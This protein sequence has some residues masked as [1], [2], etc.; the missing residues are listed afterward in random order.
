MPFNQNKQI[1]S[2]II[3]LFS[4]YKRKLALI[5]LCL[6]VFT[7]ASIAYP[8]L[9]KMLIDDGVLKQDFTT[10]CIIVAM[11][12]GTIILSSLAEMLKEF[13]R[14][15]IASGI[16]QK[17]VKDAFDSFL[18][19]DITYF[20]KKNSAE[21]L[22]DL[23]TDIGNLNKICDNSVFFVVTQLLTFCGGIVGL[24]VIDQR[25]AMLVFL[26][27]PAKYLCVHYFSNR[28]KKQFNVL[29][30]FITSFGHW[31]GDSLNGIKDIRLFG[32]QNKMQDE[33]AKQVFSVAN[34]QRKVTILQ[35]MNLCSEVFLIHSLEAILLLTGAYFILDNS[36]T[37][38]SLFAFISYSMQVL[39]PI[40]AVLNIKFLLSGII[41]SAE[42]Y[43]LLLDHSSEHCEQGGSEPVPE[44][45]ELAFRNVSFAYGDKY[46][47]K[48]ANLTVGQGEKIAIIGQNGAGKSTVFSLIERFFKPNQGIITLN[49][50]DISEYD[51]QKYRASFS[52]IGQDSFLFNRSVLDNLCM[53]VSYS[54]NNLIERIKECGLQEL[55][56]ASS[57]GENGKQLSGGQRQK[58]LLAR[59]LLRNTSWYL[60]DEATSNMDTESENRLL[61]LLHTTLKEKTVLM[62]VHNMSLLQHF[63]SIIHITGDGTIRQYASYKE[64]VQCEP[65]FFETA[66]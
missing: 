53:S 22:N 47:L 46:V 44:F 33:A 43:F 57:V 58:I 25:L 31:F 10:V 66:S 3:T 19:V 26:F 40:S 63:E 9:N 23:T 13:L 2:R 50:K 45:C 37:M 17:L 11:M 41:P 35:S 56:I 34:A 12:L 61:D 5:L 36:L 27:I 28:Q 1:I 54:E 32:I 59:A 7:A 55:Q 48:D 14:A 52:A 51:L 15:D 49:G 60:F 21:M 29:L 65:T 64:V 20:T 24:F 8:L 42:R 18:R 62:I 16:H 4:F 6:V 38:G 39:D 30:N